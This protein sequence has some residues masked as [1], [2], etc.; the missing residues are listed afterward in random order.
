MP[1][2]SPTFPEFFLFGMLRAAKWPRQAGLLKKTLVVDPRIVDHLRVQL[3]EIGVALGAGRPRLAAQLLAD[4]LGNQD[5]DAEPFSELSTN[6]SSELGWSGLS[7]SSSVLPWECMV[8]THLSA[9]PNVSKP[10]TL[11]WD[12]LDKTEVRVLFHVECVAG[13]VWGLLNPIA[14]IEAFRVRLAQVERLAPAMGQ[15]NLNIDTK[16]LAMTP[17]AW[18]Q[19]S[20]DMVHAYQEECRLLPAVPA[21][22]ASS[23]ELAARLA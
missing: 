1:T 3:V 4:I 16:S 20:E 5:W 21:A 22:L 9:E 23:P 12:W 13:L 2:V 8:R 18:F 7:A 15:T 19:Q 6:L 11:R 17:E 14:A 10:E